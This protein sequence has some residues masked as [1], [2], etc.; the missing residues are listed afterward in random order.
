MASLD[1]KTKGSLAAVCFALAFCFSQLVC[2][3]D[4]SRPQS[5]CIRVLSGSFTA[6]GAPTEMIFG[7]CGWYDYLQF[8][9]GPIRPIQ[10]DS[11]RMAHT[12]MDDETGLDH[13]V[14]DTS[15]V[16]SGCMPEVGVYRVHAEH[17]EKKALEKVF[18]MQFMDYVDSIR[19]IV[20]ADGA[21]RWRGLDASR[22]S[23]DAAWASLVDGQAGKTQTNW[24]DLTPGQ[25]VALSVRRLP[26]DIMVNA[27]GAIAVHSSERTPSLSV[28]VMEARYHYDA[29]QRA[30]R[31]L[32]V[33][34]H[35]Y[36]G[37][38]SVLLVKDQ[39]RG[40][41]AVI[42]VMGSDHDCLKGGEHEEA[43]GALYVKDGKLYTHESYEY[44]GDEGLERFE[45]WFEIDLHGDTVTRLTDRPEFMNFIA[46]EEALGQIELSL[47]PQ[48][49]TA[50]GGAGG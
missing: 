5:D 17:A 25:T 24:R 31:I 29:D 15:C 38:S 4:E 9:D 48:P 22:S 8:K 27:L 47:L 32:E 21:C 11:W 18:S 1:S 30:W 42:R 40:R 23:L 10:S 45:G 16:G 12:C 6:P 7:G 37:G 14:L 50:G 49:F 33:G 41:W 19:E 2:A 13:I 36:C 28:N 20:A 46:D 43:L 44:Y 39:L 35:S 3:A 34:R 26:T